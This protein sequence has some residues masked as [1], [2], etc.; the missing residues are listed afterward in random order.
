MRFVTGSEGSKARPGN[1]TH[2]Y[3]MLTTAEDFYRN[4]Y[5]ESASEDSLFG[6]NSSD[7]SLG[8]RFSRMRLRQGDHWLDNPDL[9]EGSDVGPEDGADEEWS[10]D[11][12]LEQYRDRIMKRLENDI[13]EGKS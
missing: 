3:T 13:A 1:Q 6:G 7:S 4:D 5:P 10:E 9:L 8:V 11:E 2:T 12:S